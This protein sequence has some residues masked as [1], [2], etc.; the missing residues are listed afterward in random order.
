MNTNECKNYPY[1]IILLGCYVHVYNGAAGLFKMHQKTLAVDGCKDS[2]TVTCDESDKNTYVTVFDLSNLCT[3]FNPDT[4]SLYPKDFGF[5]NAADLINHL[6]AV[7]NNEVLLNCCLEQSNPLTVETVVLVPAPYIDLKL[8]GNLM[9]V[10][11]LE[12]PFEVYT[13]LYLDGIGGTFEVSFENPR[14]ITNNKDFINLWNICLGN[15]IELSAKDADTIWVKDNNAT[16]DPGGINFTIEAGGL[17]PVYDYL[18][19]DWYAG[20][21]PTI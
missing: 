18:V 20:N 10:V 6:S 17:A 15:L 19:D 11:P 9:P 8:P 3:G 12:F 13:L 7:A 1:S 16:T 4:A 21:K 2:L 5:D 14:V